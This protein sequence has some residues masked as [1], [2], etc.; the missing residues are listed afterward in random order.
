M[1]LATLKDGTPDGQLLVVSR[2]LSRAAPARSVT[3]N[4]REALER[5]PQVAGGLEQ[6]ASQLEANAVAG[7]FPLDTARLGAPLPRAWQWLDA[8]AFHCHGDLLEKVFGSEPPPD[9]RTIPLMYQGAAD[10]FL[11]PCDDVPLPS[12]A[13][14]IDFE[15]E[16][17]VITDRVPMG[18]PAETA[19]K[20]IRLVMLANDWSL[21]ALAGRELRTG[22]GFLQAKPATSFSPVAITPDELGPDGWR[23][24][25]VQLDLLVSW[26]GRAFGHPNA[27]T[28]GFSFGQLIAHA[29]ATRN[30]AAGTIIGSGTVSNE[31]Y[32]SVGSACIA[33]RR[34]IEMLDE[35]AAKTSYMKFGDRA[36]I[37][38]LDRAG[39]SIF[40]AIDQRVVP[41][42]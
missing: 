23:E 39:K 8:S 18:T 2:D 10:D 41:L 24:G 14:G 29:A 42:R 40:G 9:K 6:L 22:F 5:W 33:E 19:Q 13:Q 28:M 20:H 30:L 15:G 7:A 27:G 3:P 4:L 21:R 26:N 1:K 25:R 32:R 37:E 34:G 12:E 38:M 16:V 11:G 36:R 17:V 31:D 35:G